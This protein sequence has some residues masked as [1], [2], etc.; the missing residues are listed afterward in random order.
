[1]MFPNQNTNEY[2]TIPINYGAIL[3]SIFGFVFAWCGASILEASE[4]YMAYFIIAASILVFFGSLWHYRL[5]HQ[6]VTQFY[7]GVKR[8]K[9]LWENV[10]QV[11]V[12]YTT[13]YARG[14]G[15]R[16]IIIVPKWCELPDLKQHNG[17]AYVRRN[18]RRI[19]KF[20]CNR[21]NAELIEKYYGALDFDCRPDH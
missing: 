20:P 13:T 19:M 14:S 12:I 8:R 11:G 4:K 6:G 3:F 9:I 15:Q 18:R 10:A 2:G 7:F 21:K 1:M 5:D 17:Q 16:H